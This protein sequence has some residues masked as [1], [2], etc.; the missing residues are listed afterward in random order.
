MG[1]D[2]H[3]ALSESFRAKLEGALNESFDLEPGSFPLDR[4]LGEIE[5]WD[6]MNSV[7][8]TLAL[9]SAFGV[10]LDGVILT[11]EQTLADVAGILLERGASG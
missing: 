1:R 11:A 7:N 8:L 4:A 3:P 9:E 5:G 10:E 6:S 2:S